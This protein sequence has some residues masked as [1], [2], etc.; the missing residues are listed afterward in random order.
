VQLLVE[1]FQL[2]DVHRTEF[3]PTLLTHDPRYRLHLGVILSGAA[4]SLSFFFADPLVSINLA[5]CAS[6]ALTDL[7]FSAGDAVIN[8]NG[9]MEFQFASPDNA[10]FFRIESR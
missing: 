6:L 4:T 8:G 3:L 9:E 1:L 7:P 5:Q 10:A 2:G